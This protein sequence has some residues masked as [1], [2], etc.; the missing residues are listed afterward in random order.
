MLYYELVN[1]ES[2]VLPMTLAYYIGVAAPSSSVPK[3][4]GVAR[5]VL[6]W[7]LFF[8]LFFGLRNVV[9]TLASL[10]TCLFPRMRVCALILWRARGLFV[11]IRR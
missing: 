8:V 10:L 2:L 9:P 3:W 4:G 7:V 5:S 1:C 11:G 6:G